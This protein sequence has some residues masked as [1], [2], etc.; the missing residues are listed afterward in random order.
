MDVPLY[1]LLQT[2]VSDRHNKKHSSTPNPHKVKNEMLSDS[3][4]YTHHITLRPHKHK[5]THSSLKFFYEDLPV[6]TYSTYS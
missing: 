5:L 2:V 6:S 3:V 4:P 1:I